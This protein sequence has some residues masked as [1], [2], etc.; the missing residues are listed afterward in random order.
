MSVGARKRRGVAT[1][2][3]V[4]SPSIGSFD[5]IGRAHHRTEDGKR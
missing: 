5:E 3:V 2:F 4:L 1:E